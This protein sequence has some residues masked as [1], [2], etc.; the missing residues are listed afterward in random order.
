M[1]II[2]C[3]C[4]LI[5]QSP[6]PTTWLPWITAGAGLAGAVIGAVASLAGQMLV[7]RAI[8]KREARAERRQGYAEF[9]AAAFRYVAQ[10]EMF[11]Q[12][13]W[14]VERINTEPESESQEERR[15]AAVADWRKQM[16]LRRAALDE[17]TIAMFRLL[18]H[19]PSRDL[20]DEA[21]NMCVYLSKLTVQATNEEQKTVQVILAVTDAAREKI[22]AWI[23]DRV[24]D[25]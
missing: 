8:R 15:T 4:H 23:K 17:T 9:G 10:L 12:L 13:K 7:Q 18:A 22:T 16:D 3:Q 19:L 11:T 1:L 2:A 14:V 20:Q 25:L 21:Q 6:A 5:A 24:I